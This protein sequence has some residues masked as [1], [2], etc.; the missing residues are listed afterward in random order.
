MISNFDI[1]DNTTMKL[2]PT[3]RGY[4]YVIFQLESGVFLGI[5]HMLYVLELKVSLLLVVSFEDEGYAIAF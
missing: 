5:E 1:N 3:L 4:G 2:C